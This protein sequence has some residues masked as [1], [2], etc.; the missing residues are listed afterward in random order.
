MKIGKSVL[1][2]F[3]ILLDNIINYVIMFLYNREVEI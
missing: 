2:L 1:Y 3:L